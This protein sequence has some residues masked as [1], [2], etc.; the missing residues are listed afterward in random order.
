MNDFNG[1]ATSGSVNVDRWLETYHQFRNFVVQK[2]R[3]PSKS[4]ADPVE[5]K[6]ARWRIS[7][8]SAYAGT[9]NGTK[10][11]DER[12]ALLESIPGWTWSYQRDLPW[13][14]KVA[15]LREFIQVNNR[16]PYASSSI[17]E[18]R[19]LGIFRNQ[20]KA[21]WADSEKREQYF[22]PERISALEALPGWSWGSPYATWETQYEAYSK[23]VTHHSRLPNAANSS[24][25]EQ[26]LSLWGGRQQD[27]HVGK[28]GIRPLTNEQRVMLEAIPEWKWRV[29]PQEKWVSS[30]QAVQ[31]MIQE[32][33][34]ITIH[35]LPD[36]SSEWLRNQ[37]RGWDSLAA[38]QQKL[39]ASFEMWPPAPKINIK[40]MNQYREALLLCSNASLRKDEI[41]ERTRIWLERQQQKLLAYNEDKQTMLLQL[42]CFPLED[43]PD[44][45]KLDR[46][47][48]I[49]VRKARPQISKST[50]RVSPRKIITIAS[51]PSP[52]KTETKY[53]SVELQRRRANRQ[54]T[55][56]YEKTRAWFTLTP[57]KPLS[58]E[59]DE[60]LA[61]QKRERQNL[62]Y[63]D[64]KRLTTLLLIDF[65]ELSSYRRKEGEM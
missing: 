27:K 4:S 16:T 43:F 3:M 46:E 49:T 61:E 22:T 62:V 45:P 28:P 17:P 36:E 48:E 50:P 57:E 60:W 9:N 42:R 65:S 2:S 23:F 26:A 41:P 40:W 55:T 39:L 6:L 58:P 19:K 30:L 33:P 12:I 37:L 34:S 54:W 59:L 15:A 25:N 31:K 24:A 51:P 1:E 38:D 20:Q 35:A 21:H 10:L 11:T 14:E 29:T 8:K 53:F 56:M 44:L 7:F 18:E 32:N 13:L 63:A 5:Q 47:E 52:E 64:Q